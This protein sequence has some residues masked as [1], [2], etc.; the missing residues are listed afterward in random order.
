[1]FAIA[2]T[3]LVLDLNVPES[4]FDDLL[5]AIA[6]EWPAYLGYATS[7]LMIGGIWLAHRVIFRSMQYANS[8]IIRLN[9]VLLM[10]VS[11][12]PFPTRL[13]AEAIRNVHAERTAVVFYGLALFAVSALMTALRAST[14]RDRQLLK[15]Q[16]SEQQI[17]A[18]TRTAMPNTILLLAALLLAI[19]VPRAAVIGYLVIAVGVVLRARGDEPLPTAAESA[20]DVG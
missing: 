15:P 16:V 4:G 3:L 11:F 2:I 17:A 14:V 12:L 1:M 9:L 5:G 20:Q 13:M 10:A 7:F 8:T 18:V 6:H 19:I